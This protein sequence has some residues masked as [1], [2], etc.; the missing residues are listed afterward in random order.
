MKFIFIIKMAKY[1]RAK[2]WYGKKNFNKIAKNYTKVRIDRSYRLLLT[3][4]RINFA[5]VNANHIA[6]QDA[7]STMPDYQMYR[8]LYHSMKLTGVAILAVPMIHSQNYAGMNTISLALMTNN[9]GINIGNVV[10]SDRSLILNFQ[11]SQR[12][13][14][15]MHSGAT[16]WIAVD[17][18]NRLPGKIAAAVDDL[19]TAGEAYWV[20]KLS[21]WITF[22]NK[23]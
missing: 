12:A 16:G 21:F 1:K 6:L 8:Q 17:D 11:Q 7:I 18:V 10:E 23:D 2:K 13:Y 15:S 20:V 9:D 22:K 14:W 3:T 4:Q 5:D 19:P